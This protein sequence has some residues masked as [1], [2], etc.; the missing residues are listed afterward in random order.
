MALVCG[1]L[2][3]RLRHEARVAAERE[4]RAGAL[5]RLARDLSGALTQA[6]VVQTALTTVSGV[7]DA[8]TGLLLPD[9]Q[10]QLH[11]APGSEAAID[12]SV[13]AGAWSTARW[14]AGVR[15]PWPRRTRCMCR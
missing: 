7:F 14:R 5:A 9:A 6:Q 3:A 15:T 2:M 13:A 12:A 11:V 8:R 10:E 1:Q 4:R